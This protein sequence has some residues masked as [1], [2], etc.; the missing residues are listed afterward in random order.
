MSKIS[1]NSH[2]HAPAAAFALIPNGRYHAVIVDSI[3]RRARSGDGSFLQLAFQI[4]TGDHKDRVIWARLHLNSRNATTVR[5]A[6]AE[7]AAVCKAVGCAAINDS[8]ELH[9][10]PLLID[11]GRRVRDSGDIVNCI[12]SYEVIN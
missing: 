9:G 11:V 12:A 4:I 3:T 2:D 1:F 10:K 5:I 6:Q 7:L 8:R